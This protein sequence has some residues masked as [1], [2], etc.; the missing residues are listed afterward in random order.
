MLTLEDDVDA[1]ALHRRGWK[2]AAIA[3]HLGR[4]RKTVR[5]YLSGERQVGRR[6]RAAPDPFAAYQP[7]LEA[8]FQDDPHV[9]ATAL[10]DEVCGLGYARSYP[11]FT[12][13]LRTR[14]LRPHCEPCAGV[15]GRATI[16][17]DHPAGEEIQWD[18]LEFE[19]TPWGEP[20][21]LLV[22]TL[23][24]SGKTRAVFAEAEDQPH[25]I[26][27]I[28]AVLRRL[29]G[30]ARRWRFDRMGTVVSVGTD[31]VLASFAAVAKHYGVHIKICPPRRGNR[32]GCVEKK[33]HFIAQRWWR[34]A[35]VTTPEAAQ[36]SLDRFLS[37]T[38]DARPRHGVT[39]AEAAEHENL[40]PLPPLPYPATVEVARK[41][42]DSAL[43]AFRGNKYSVPPGLLG[44][45]LVVRHR[46]GTGMLEIVA[47]NARVVARHL[48]AAG[49]GGIHRLHDHRVALEGV[50][51]AAFT[52]APR[53]RRKENRPP[54]PEA[55][56]A[57]A[58]LRGLGEDT[59]VVVDLSQY[60]E[61]LEVAS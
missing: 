38:A 24:Y 13:E 20:A 30:T 18:W 2:I 43:V 32:K 29:G 45:D 55:R 28:D 42:G 19:D 21:H 25:L 34:T 10:H 11:R 60:A 26:E 31:R 33:N 49:T 15:K 56:A 48:V 9:W 17:I 22:G 44:A 59:E 6:R 58:L 50:V 7:Y 37:T 14:A 3:R 27:A 12:A 8:R 52:T 51:L 41:V 16:E 39:A 54:G 57:A 5:A 23:A 35:A 1:H 53:C 4:D 46:L 47:G 61:L 40:M 36:L